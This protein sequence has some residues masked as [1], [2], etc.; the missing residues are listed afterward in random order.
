MLIIS[1]QWVWN[2]VSG[3]TSR[4]EQMFPR[5]HR[6]VQEI[7]F[8]ITHYVC[9][10]IVVR[11][12]WNRTS[13]SAAHD[14]PVCSSSHSYALFFSHKKRPRFFLSQVFVRVC[15]LNRILL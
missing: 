10:Q 1:S 11:K 5:Q 7:D 8:R 3:S 15:V 4:S 6:W 2:S 14:V 13:Q 12:L 9:D